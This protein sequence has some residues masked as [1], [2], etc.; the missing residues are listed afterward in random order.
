MKL[1]KHNVKEDKGIAR[2]R[3]LG[4]KT[5]KR[6]QASPPRKQPTETTTHVPKNKPISKPSTKS[7]PKR[8]AKK[9]I[10]SQKTDYSHVRS[11]T[12]SHHEAGAGMDQAH[13]TR[14]EQLRMAQQ[15]YRRQ[16]H[17]K[18][19]AAQ[20]DDVVIGESSF[21]VTHSI[22]LSMEERQDRLQ[23]GQQDHQQDH[24]TE[25][26][27]NDGQYYND[28]EEQYE[29]ESQYGNEYN[30]DY[31]R[32]EEQRQDNKDYQYEEDES[33]ERHER[34]V[35]DSMGGN[36]GGS[37]QQHDMDTLMKMYYHGEDTMTKLPTGRLG[38]NDLMDLQRELESRDGGGGGGGGGGS[39]SHNGN[40][41]RSSPLRDVG[42][43]GGGEENSV[44][45][46]VLPH[47][48][49]GQEDDDT[50]EKNVRA[51]EREY[52]RLGGAST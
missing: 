40:G 27:S 45:P 43:G 29:D 11:K 7:K 6:L 15:Q 3:R 48:L 21:P 18:Q 17:Q 1:V 37:V 2:A 22:D 31:Y 5:S 4:A 36:M 12:S 8:A 44:L 42:R 52:Q 32:E 50:Y 30:E 16:Q 41:Q 20:P 46:H 33:F 25:D 13:L 38:L 26:Y 35:G 51:L 49:D 39:G 19:T 23:S 9:K 10:F 47:T 14:H 28:G 34:E 24:Q